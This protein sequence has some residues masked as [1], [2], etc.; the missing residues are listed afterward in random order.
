MWTAHARRARSRHSL[1]GLGEVVCGRAARGGWADRRWR[2][3]EDGLVI[4]K[5]CGRGQEGG[6]AALSSGL[7]QRCLSVGVETRSFGHRN[8]C[9]FH[10]WIKS[11]RACEGAC[12]SA[13]CAV[14]KKGADGEERL[15]SN[16]CGCQTTR[17]GF[18]GQRVEARVEKR[19]V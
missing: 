10:S 3:G 13:Q 4:G 5:G 1:V 11:L 17:N 16:E 15:T 8:A 2:R 19:S 7:A 9:A 6:R 18:A 12:R 14:A